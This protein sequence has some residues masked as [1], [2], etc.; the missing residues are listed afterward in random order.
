MTKEESDAKQWRFKRYSHYLKDKYGCSAYRVG[1]DC[2]FS[3]PNRGA[4]REQH[5]CTYCETYGAAAIYQD[6]FLSIREQVERA[7]AFLKRRYGA[8]VFL[9]YLQ[10][11]SNTYDTVENLKRI[12]DYSLGLGEFRELIVSTRPDC[13]DN[14]KAALLSGYRRDDFDVW[15]ELGL[16]SSHN[17]TLKA[18]HRGHTVEQFDQAFRLLRSA[19]IKLSVHLILGLPGESWEDIE[20]TVKYV[21]SLKPE[22]VKLHNLHI[23]YNTIMYRQYE[24]GEIDTVSFET[25]LDYVVKTLELLPPETV[26][27]RVVADTP[28]ERLAAPKDFGNKCI[29]IEVL[30]RKME[31]L[32][33]FQGC[34]F[35]SL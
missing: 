14:E 6:S 13:L 33:T 8:E 23:P 5:G 18:I 34:K 1:V 21:A 29:F 20:A 19:G 35:Q 4:S 26:I 16:Q 3:C 27:Q 9:L 11:F 10:A 32:N 31:E 24:K 12:Y 15:V 7:L 30:E 17:R 22:A 2:G 28:K 25:Y